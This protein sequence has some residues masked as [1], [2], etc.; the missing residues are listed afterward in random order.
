MV[1]N[2]PGVL[3][4]IILAAGSGSRIKDITRGAIKCLLPIANRPMIL[5]PINKLIQAGFKGMS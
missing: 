3:T 1:S 5:Y 4:A 2:V